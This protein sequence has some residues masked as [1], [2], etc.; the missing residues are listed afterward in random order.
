MRYEFPVFSTID[1]TYCMSVRWSVHLSFRWSLHAMLV[2]IKICGF[3]FIYRHIYTHTSTHIHTH[4]HTHTSTHTHKHTRAHTFLEATSI[5][6]SGSVRPSVR[7]MFVKM[8]E[9]IELDRAEL[10]SSPGLRISG[11]CWSCIW[12]CF[13]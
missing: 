13:R 10:R 2:L 4:L 3:R 8:V 7:A 11:I 6:L 1:A 9:I 12:P 5:S